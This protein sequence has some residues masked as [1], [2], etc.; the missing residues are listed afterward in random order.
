MDYRCL[1]HDRIFEASTDQR[2]PGS[3]A[4]ATLPAMPFN[5][6]PDCP[7]C[8]EELTA[9]TESKADKVA[10]ARAKQQAAD[11]AVAE[12]K[13]NARAAQQAAGAAGNETE[14]AVR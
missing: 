13:A 10:A 1:K 6:H 14:P 12:A 9:K 7:K 5:G 4:T 2:R 8:A 11:A 3:G